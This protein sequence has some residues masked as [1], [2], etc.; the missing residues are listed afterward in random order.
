MGQSRQLN[1]DNPNRGGQVKH[2]LSDHNMQSLDEKIQQ[3]S[4]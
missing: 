3:N 2:P 1:S 4:P